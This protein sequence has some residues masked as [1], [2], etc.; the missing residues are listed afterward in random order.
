M[1]FQTI[2]GQW[3]FASIVRKRTALLTWDPQGDPN[4]KSLDDIKAV[5]N[6]YYMVYFRFMGIIGQILQKIL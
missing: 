5:F 3:R 2:T 1:A 4:A 6:Y